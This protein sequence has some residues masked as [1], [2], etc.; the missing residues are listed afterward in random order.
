MKMLLRDLGLV[1]TKQ[2]G[3]GGV[4]SVGEVVYM[5]CCRYGL[6]FQLSLL[7]KLMKRDRVSCQQDPSVALINH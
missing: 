6:G 7:T 1:V 3:I 4:E 5:S 2:G